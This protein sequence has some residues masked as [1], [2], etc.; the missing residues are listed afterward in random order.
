ML[1]GRST[2]SYLADCSTLRSNA[3]KRSPRANDVN[4]LVSDVQV[5]HPTGTPELQ[6]VKLK[7]LI[8]SFETLEYRGEESAL[9]GSAGPPRV[10]VTGPDLGAIAVRASRCHA[11]TKTKHLLVLLDLFRAAPTCLKMICEDSHPSLSLQG[12]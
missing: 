2:V 1:G 6:R 4:V 3:T 12:L 10:N 11:L 8:T 5:M 9:V 7:V